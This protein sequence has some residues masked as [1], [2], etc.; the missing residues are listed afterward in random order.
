MSRARIQRLIA[1]GN[2]TVDGR[3]VRKSAT[4]S[5]GARIVV[6]LDSTRSPKPVPAAAEGIVVLFE[7][8]ALLAVAKPAGVVVHDAPGAPAPSVAGW[9]V[10]RF[11]EEASAFTAGRPGIVHRLD[12]DTT[13]VLV[14]ARTPQSQ[15]LL[16]RAFEERSVAKTYVALTGGRP[17]RPRGS[18]ETAIGRDPADRTRM[19]V[20]PHGRDAVTGF[21]VVES[22]GEHALLEI[23]PRTGRTH[24]IRVHLSA[25]G[26]PVAGDRVYGRV[27][28]ARQMLHAWRIE[29]PHPSGGRL[30]V[31]AP[32][33]ADFRLAAE[34]SGLG[35]AAVRYCEP[36][37]A[38]R[39]PD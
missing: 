16:G 23:H 18:V 27:P 30:E 4:V 35:R 39:L 14:L 6:S 29:L 21:S 15:H 31:T 28:A 3:R 2:V 8:E 22:S 20:V 1:D 13:G 38:R 25:L 19:A 34:S 5:E 33:P 24:Q 37:P 17:P 9:F 26:C 12:R 32:L 36:S 11:P 10:A 7:D